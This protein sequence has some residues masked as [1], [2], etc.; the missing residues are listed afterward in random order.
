M[1]KKFS[2]TMPQR[3]FQRGVQHNK[4]NCSRDAEAEVTVI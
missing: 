1:A 4:E 2:N 3:N